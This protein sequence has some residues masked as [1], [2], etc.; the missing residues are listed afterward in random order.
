[1]P[2][3]GAESDRS[4]VTGWRARVWVEGRDAALP[5]SK[6]LMAASIMAT[7]IP[8]G[9]A[10]DLAAWIELEV[11]SLGR[12]R[13]V[14]DELADIAA[15][16]LERH[17]GPT[18]ARRYLAWRQAKRS[19]R[20]MVVLIGGATGVGKST[21]ATKL[22]ARLGIPRVIP[23][24]TVREVMRT[25][26]PASDAPELH[27]S[28]FE[29]NDLLSADRGDPVIDGFMSQARAV[30]AGLEALIG[31]M[32]VERKDTVIE[33]VHL[34]P[35]AVDGEAL[36][37]FRS[38][39]V[40]VKVLLTLDD[41]RVHQGHFLARLDNEHG[42]RPERYLRHLDDIRRI[43]R[44]LRQLA[45]RHGIPEVDAA[46]LD[47]A[48]QQVLDLVVAEVTSTTAVTESRTAQAG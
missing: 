46:D 47:E 31:R 36:F 32:V 24:D 43:Q 41:R 6:G 39:A 21:I 5:Y 7:G 2:H 29:V 8:P 22:A 27:T 37:R 45:A 16:V 19:P 1:M 15:A 3:R 25:F 17:A 14:A 9:R 38:E 12:D 34:V 23:T 42:R 28:S 11:T 44:H 48:I 40:V 26:I 30:A 18:I 4:V 13:V 10:F 35:G 33:G 20:P